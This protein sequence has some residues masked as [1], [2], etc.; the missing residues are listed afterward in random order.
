MVKLRFLYLKPLMVFIFK[1]VDNGIGIAKENIKKITN[2]FI[3]KIRVDLEYWRV[4][5]RAIYC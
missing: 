4:W 5:F 2:R 1:I 3:E